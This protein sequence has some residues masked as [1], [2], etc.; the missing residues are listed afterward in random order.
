MTSV[1]PPVRPRND[2]SNLPAILIQDVVAAIDTDGDPNENGLDIHWGPDTSAHVNAAVTPF[3]AYTVADQMRGVSLNDWAQVTN[4]TNNRTIWARVGDSASIHP[5]GE[6]S[7][8]A[9]AQLGIQFYASSDTVSD[10]HIAIVYYLG[11]AGN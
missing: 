9:A 8:A 11:S 6:I 3:V 7:E 5:E 1:P 2:P 4:L 10:D